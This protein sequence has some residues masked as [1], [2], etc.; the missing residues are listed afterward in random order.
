[1]AIIIALSVT[2]CGSGAGGSDDSAQPSNN[3]S[4]A[5]NTNTSSNNSDSSSTNSSSNNPAN[6]TTV[7]TSNYIKDQ[8][9]AKTINSPNLNTLQV[10]G[11]N[12]QLTFPGI[13]V[14]TFLV[15]KENA[16]SGGHLSYARYG[17]VSAN[18][19]RYAFSQGYSTLDMPTTGTAIYTGQATYDKGSVRA[20]TGKSIFH[21]DYGKK[22]ING[23]VAINSDNIQ[24]SGTING[25]AFSGNKN[26]TQMQGGFYGPK[27][28]ELS[29][30]FQNKAE[31]YT[32]AF[33]ARK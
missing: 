8:D 15:I 18:N 5:T 32:G 19:S 33:G 16:I 23:T 11:Q 22:T 28:A 25:N 30:T 10:D 12:V 21:V 14:G 20:E 27:A 24:L 2:A 17:I 9:V 4:S 26:G 1:M 6:T 13:S 29:G 3:N 7:L 31:G